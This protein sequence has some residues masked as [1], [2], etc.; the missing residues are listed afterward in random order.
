MLSIIFGVIAVKASGTSE[1]FAE[2]ISTNTKIAVNTGYGFYESIML[3][4]YSLTKYFALAIIPFKQSAFH[5]YPFDVGSMPSYFN[6]YILFPILLLSAFVY[7]WIK[8]WKIIVFSILFFIFNI[9]IVLKI[10]NFIISEHYLYIPSIGL[11]FI[12]IFLSIKLIEFKK[13]FKNAILVLSVIYILFLSYNTFER[14]KI[15]TNSLTFWND[16]TEKYPEVIVAYFNRG[17]YLQEQGDL[18]LINNTNKSVDFYN[19]AINEY[20]L[21]VN[22]HPQNKDAY[23]NRG[24]TYAKIRDYEKAIEDF[25]KVISIDSSYQN[26]YSNRGNAYAMLNMWDKA[27]NDY[28]T[29]ING[30]PDFYDAI[31]N[32][33]VA[34]FKVNRYK[35]AIIDLNSVVNIEKYT[36][37]ALKHRAFSYYFDN[38]YRKALNDLNLYLRNVNSDYNAM[39]YQALSFEKLNIMDSAEMVFNNLRINYPQIID[40]IKTTAINLESGADYNNSVELYEKALELFYDILKIDVNNSEAYLRIGVVYG[41]LGDLTLSIKMLTEAIKLNADNDEAYTNR[42]Y[43]YNLLN[44]TNLA[45]DDY[46]KAIS[47]NPQSVTAF[48]NR[49]LLFEKLGNINNAL[50]DINNAIKFDTTYS[51]AYF[52]RGILY[53]K[54]GKISLACKDWKHAVSQGVSDAQ[55]Y[56]NKYCN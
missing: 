38:Q 28:N 48:F 46:N 20:T 42:G 11:S 32:R 14:N 37:D 9:F 30:K 50:I 4:S 55:S 2:S 34:F 41:K 13:S 33:G 1:P 17:N 43:A 36:N 29:A 54:S 22:L 8:K 6:L 26:V 44:N 45:L 47:L 39:F 16:V 21:T 52:R 24:I 56:L 12:L 5:P 35:D 31:Y 23:S 19:K 27:I 3:V 10:K 49:A 18:A 40:D 15:F 7:S 53:Q 51:T 25:N